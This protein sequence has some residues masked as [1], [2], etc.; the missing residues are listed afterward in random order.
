MSNDDF[1]GGA[2]LRVFEIIGRGQEVL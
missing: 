1:V 2:N